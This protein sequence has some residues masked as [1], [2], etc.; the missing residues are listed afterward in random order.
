MSKTN[1]F[2]SFGPQFGLEIGG[3]GPRGPS[4]GSATAAVSYYN[5]GNAQ[6]KLGD[7]TSALQSHQR[8]LEIRRKTLGEN[9]PDT[10]ASYDNIGCTQHV[11]GDYTSALQSH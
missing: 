5:I 6:L 7:Y 8:A 9:H 1:F 11:F 4:P 2:G 3:P 10:A